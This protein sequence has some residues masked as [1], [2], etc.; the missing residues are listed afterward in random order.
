MLKNIMLKITLLTT[1]LSSLFF[2]SIA[3]AHPE[4]ASLLQT[5]FG[6]HLSHW[7]IAHQGLVIISALSL[8]IVL[9]YA[10]LLFVAKLKTSTEKK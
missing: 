7:L 9:I 4:H 6:E 5:M 1:A 8:L 2:S 10:S 3:T